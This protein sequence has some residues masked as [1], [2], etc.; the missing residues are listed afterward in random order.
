MT[1]V[2]NQHKGIAMDLST[3]PMTSASNLV[4]LALAT[5]LFVFGIVM[6]AVADPPGLALSAFPKP[7]SLRAPF[8]S[9]DCD[10]SLI[11]PTP[12]AELRVAC[13]CLAYQSDPNQQGS[14]IPTNC[15]AAAALNWRES[16]RR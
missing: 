10:D 9:D 2:A 16:E 12:R 7:S 5:A 3:R 1:P 11:Y 4:P 15:P 14:V 6:C 13:E 8:M